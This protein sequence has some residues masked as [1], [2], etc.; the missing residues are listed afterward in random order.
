[1]NDELQQPT[2]P[3]RTMRVAHLTERYQ[4]DPR[5]IKRW[6]DTGT[7]PPPDLVINN[8]KY[9]FESSIERNERERLSARSRKTADANAA[10]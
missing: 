5:T 8:I 2:P 10:A 6:E 3:K 4:V 7:L 9:W 1:M